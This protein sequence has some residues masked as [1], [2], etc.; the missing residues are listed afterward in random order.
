ML[1]QGQS[2][3]Q[4]KKNTESEKQENLILNSHCLG[5]GWCGDQGVGR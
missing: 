1:A 3:M 2:L 4:K 5:R